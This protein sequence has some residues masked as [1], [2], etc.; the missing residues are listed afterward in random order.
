[1]IDARRGLVYVQAFDGDA[2]LMDPEVLPL[3]EATLQLA[4]LAPGALRLVGPGAGL[5]ASALRHA[6]VDARPAPD[7]AAL[8]RLAA[9][10][11]PDPTLRPLYLRAPDAKLPA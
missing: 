1:V 7:L 2:P 9:A 8:A 4:R 3:G 10:A 11:T 6:I 5:L